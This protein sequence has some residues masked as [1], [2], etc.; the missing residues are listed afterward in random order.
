MQS[1]GKKSDGQ[2]I[3]AVKDEKHGR[4]RSSLWPDH[5]NFLPE[6]YDMLVEH[7]CLSAVNWLMG[8]WEH[9]KRTAQDEVNKYSVILYFSGASSIL[10]K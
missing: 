6:C 8:T 5:S 9:G 4:Y 7:E 10:N 2:Q 1:D 3:V